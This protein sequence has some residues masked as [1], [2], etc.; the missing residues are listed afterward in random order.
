MWEAGVVVV[1]A[2]RRDGWVAVDLVGGR[3]GRGL[4]GDVVV[5]VVV[6]VRRCCC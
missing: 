1:V 4:C 6:V 2:P 3:G 5:V